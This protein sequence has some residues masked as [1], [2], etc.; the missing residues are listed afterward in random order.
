MWEL[1]L[2][3]VRGQERG[4]GAAISFPAQMEAET[5]A[6]MEG[7]RKSQRLSERQAKDHR[8]ATGKCSN[9]V[10]EGNSETP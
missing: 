6:M 5:V 10:A 2:E 4:Q 1:T 9:P 8:I 7:I 3:G